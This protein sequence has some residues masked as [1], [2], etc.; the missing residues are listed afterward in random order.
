MR[1]SMLVYD[2]GESISESLAYM[3]S[4]DRFFCF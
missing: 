3:I 2:Q 4:I 1:S